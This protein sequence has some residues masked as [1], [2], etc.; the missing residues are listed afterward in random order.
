MK[1]INTGNP[2]QNFSQIV[3]YNKNLNEKLRNLLLIDQ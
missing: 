1:S 3:R 2:S